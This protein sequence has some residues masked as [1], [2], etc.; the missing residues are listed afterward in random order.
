MTAPSDRDRAL[1]QRYRRDQP[2]LPRPDAL[3]LAAYAERRPTVTE[4]GEIERA[5]AR[6]PDMLDAVLAIRRS[7]DDAPVPLD[8]IRRARALVP[9][10]VG[11]RRLASWASIAAALV[12]VCV[13]GF[14]AGY[15]V[16]GRANDLNQPI[17]LANW[18]GGDADGLD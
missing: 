7:D 2:A 4:I 15:S 3:D 6:D 11:P 5:L 1:W 13:S 18:S 12:L 17:E 16:G 9:S 8:I 10:P 14:Q